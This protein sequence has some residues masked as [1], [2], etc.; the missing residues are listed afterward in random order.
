MSPEVDVSSSAPGSAGRRSL[1]ELLSFLA[2]GGIGFIIDATVLTALTLY[3]GWSP[4]LAR[5]PSFLTA[6]LATWALN[7]RHTFTNRGLHRRSTEAFFYLS[8]QTGGAL[9]NLAIFWVC[10]RWQPRLAA[11][12]VIPLAFGS[13]GGLV[14]NYLMSSRWLYRRLRSKSDAS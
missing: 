7:R 4:W 13:A 3:A 14:F 5:I 9:I 2:V 1:R 12:P 10:L 6:V 8:I 11:A